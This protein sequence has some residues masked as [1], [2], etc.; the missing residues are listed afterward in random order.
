MTEKNSIT[1]R[2][3]SSHQKWWI[4][5]FSTGLV[6]AIIV[7]ILSPWNSAPISSPARPA[8]NY[9]EALHLIDIFR[10]QEPQEMNPL[11]RTQLMTHGKKTD[12]AII[13]VHGYTSDPQQFHDLGQQFYDSGYNVLIAPLPHHGLKN[14]MTDAH[15]RLTAEEL[16]TYAN[17]TVDIA[18]GLGERGDHDGNF[19]RRGNHCLGSTKPKRY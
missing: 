1:Q 3:I 2:L 13:L 8:Q 6:I 11:C 14:R 4:F 15:A 7:F 19:R 5:L 16:A 12:R 10:Q 18:R 17:R 9:S